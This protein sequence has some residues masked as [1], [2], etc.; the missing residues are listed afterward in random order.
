MYQSTLTLRALSTIC[1]H[2]GK[3]A[4]N[5]IPSSLHVIN[6]K[7]ISCKNS[8]CAPLCL[9]T[10]SRLLKVGVQ[11]RSQRPLGM[12]S[13]KA[14][15]I[16]SHISLLLWIPCWAPSNFWSKLCSLHHSSVQHT[17][18]RLLYFCASAQTPSSEGECV[19][20]GIPA[21]WSCKIFS[22]FFFS[23]FYTVGITVSVA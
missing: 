15:I 7:L 16:L 12:N 13:S 20:R 2:T 11:S 5:F 14:L 22:F 23:F 21:L 1:I 8:S 18:A 4:A 10:D 9:Q 3:D 17:V 19:Q 6:L